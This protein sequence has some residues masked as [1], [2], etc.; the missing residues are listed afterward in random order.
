MLCRLLLA[1]ILASLSTHAEAQH[2]Q[3]PLAT[4]GQV[5]VTP[6]YTGAGVPK[7]WA[8][9]VTATSASVKCVVE[10]V[11]LLSILNINVGSVSNAPPSGLQV[12]VIAL[13]PS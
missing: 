2:A 6:V 10:A 3:G 1:A 12:G 8:T 4:P 9:A 11:A 7:C 13:P 5:V